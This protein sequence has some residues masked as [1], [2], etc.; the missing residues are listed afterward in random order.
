[1]SD[2]S[3]GNPVAQAACSNPHPSPTITKPQRLL[4]SLASWWRVNDDVHLK[5]VV[6]AASDLGYDG[7]IEDRVFGPA[8]LIRQIL[9]VQHSCLAPESG[10]IAFRVFRAALGSDHTADQ[11][12][13]GCYVSVVLIAIAFYRPT[14]S[15][16]RVSDYLASRRDIRSSIARGELRY[17]RQRTYDKLLASLF[18]ELEEGLARAGGTLDFRPD[19]SLHHLY[20]E[21]SQRL[22]TAFRSALATLDWPPIGGIP[23]S[24]ESSLLLSRDAQRRYMAVTRKGRGD[25]GRLVTEAWNARETSTPLATFLAKARATHDADEFD[26]LIDLL[27]DAWLLF[28]SNHAT[29]SASW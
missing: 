7:S 4:R 9:A 26:C 11:D 15:P 14:L 2:L 3:V 12:H 5:A 22:E 1:M 20:L 6:D 27:K 29:S 17:A 24:P 18:P 8:G 23:L 28:P 10:D 19:A 16:A 25:C 21:D 13:G